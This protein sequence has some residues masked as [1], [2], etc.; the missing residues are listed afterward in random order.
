MKIVDFLRKESCVASLSSLVKED[1]LKELCDLL[2]KNGDVDDGEA[3][4]DAVIKREQLGSTGIGEHVAIPHAKS[5]G[6]KNLVAAFGLS[7]EGVDYV[8]VDDKPV[9]IIF[10]LVASDNATGAHLKALARI[11]RLLKKQ[12]FRKKLENVSSS[13]D[14]YSIIA[15]EDEALG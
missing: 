15:Q 1:V 13:E 10:L 4:F 12:D 11:S 9:R 3:I 7:K 6:V 14:I 2:S 8:S 5:P